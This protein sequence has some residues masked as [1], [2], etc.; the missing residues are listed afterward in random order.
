M[1]VK[2]SSAVYDGL[3]TR[4]AKA[5]KNYRI[6]LRAIMHCDPCPSVVELHRAV[7]LSM[8][9]DRRKD[10]MC[11]HVYKAVNT[12]STWKVNSMFSLAG[13]ERE[14]A[15]RSSERGDLAIPNCHLV[16]CHKSIS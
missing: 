4:T 8:L 1:S 6:G 15:T 16:V 9:K 11:T 7:N 10:H 14:H 3:T 13:A 5:C 12:M 2:V